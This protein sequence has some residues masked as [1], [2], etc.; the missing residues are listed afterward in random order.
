MTDSPLHPQHQAERQ[1][2]SWWWGRV[3]GLVPSHVHLIWYSGW[4]QA[5]RQIS[6]VKV[7]FLARNVYVMVTESRMSLCLR[8]LI[9]DVVILT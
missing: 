8:L 9:D 1:A 6:W 5:R 4:A 2:D 3:G 7:W